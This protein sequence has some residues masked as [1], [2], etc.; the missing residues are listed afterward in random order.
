MTGEEA[1]VITFAQTVLDQLNISPGHSQAGVVFFN[2]NADSVLD[3]PVTSSRDDIE[4]AIAQYGTSPLY[5]TSGGAT[6]PPTPLASGAARLP[7]H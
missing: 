4:A 5:P 1:G 3:P 7:E 2:A 6:C